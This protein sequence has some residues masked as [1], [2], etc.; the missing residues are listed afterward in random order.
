MR[1]ICLC[2]F[3]FVLERSIPPLCVCSCVTALCPLAASSASVISAACDDINGF[4]KVHMITF[5]SLH[6]T[7]H[8]TF[9]THL[10]QVVGVT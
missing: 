2:A 9:R 3:N 5:R 6:H 1:P 4:A 7:F 10:L 8:W